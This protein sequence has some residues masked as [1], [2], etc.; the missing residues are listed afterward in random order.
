MSLSSLFIVSFQNHSPTYQ[1][2][3]RRALLQRIVHALDGLEE[4]GVA[5]VDL[6]NQSIIT[7]FVIFTLS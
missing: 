5:K 1:A 7:T 6:K 4:D 3:E 2:L